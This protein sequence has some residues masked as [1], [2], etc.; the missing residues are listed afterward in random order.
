M[1]LGDF[2]EGL[3]GANL[4]EEVR[5]FDLGANGD[6]AQPDLLVESLGNDLETQRHKATKTQEDRQTKGI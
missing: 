2:I 6:E 5:R 3:S 4:I 1:G